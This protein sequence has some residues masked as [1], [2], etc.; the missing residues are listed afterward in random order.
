MFVDY[1]EVLLESYPSMCSTVLA[2]GI[3][4][5]GYLVLI[6]MLDETRGIY[7]SISNINCLPN[8]LFRKVKH[9]KDFVGGL[10]NFVSEAEMLRG[11]KNVLAKMKSIMW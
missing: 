6:G 1:T 4:D 8:I 2:S 7:V 3:I 11:Y 5:A 10:N 9:I